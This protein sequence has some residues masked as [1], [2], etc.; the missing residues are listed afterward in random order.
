MSNASSAEQPMHAT[1]TSAAVAERNAR[2]PGTAV[3]RIALI[4]N[5][6][7]GKT[8]LFNRLCGMRARTANFPG[9]TVD[10]RRGTCARASKPTEIIDLPGVYALDLD[11]PESMLCRDC[12]DGR[13]AECRPD[14]V[15]VVLDATNLRRSLQLAAS[16]IA[17]QKPMVVA[18]NMVDL[19]AR[20][21]LTI[22]TE[23]L[24]E[25]LGCPVR[26][27]CAR[28]GEGVDELVATLESATP[29]RRDLPLPRRGDPP[30]IA[31]TAAWADEVVRQSVGGDHALG[32]AEDTFTDRLDQAFT[33]PVLGVLVFVLVMTALFATIFWLADL[34][35]SLIE[36]VFAWM[37]S[38]VEASLPAGP[39]AELLANGVVAGVGA[40]VVFLPQ[41]CLLFFLLTLLED[42]GYLARAAFVM[43]R[44]LCRF[45]LP[46][47][48]FVPLLSSHACAIPG[49]MST[50]LIPDRHERLATILVAPFMSCSARIP[51]YVLMLGLLFAD[52]P[53]L[54]GVAFVGCYALG[55][56]AAMFTALLFRRTLLKGR[57][58]PMVLELPSY[59]LP[60]LRTAVL[61]TIDRARLFLR[62]AGSVILAIA[63]IMWWLSAYPKS[64]PPPEAQAMIVQAESSSD[65]EHAD[66]LLA[67]ADTV[68][69]RN[70]QLNSFAGRLG[71]LFQP[72]FA[73]LGAD[74]QIT[75]AILT[76]FL[77]RE[78][79]QGTM[80]ILVGMDEDADSDRLLGAVRSAKRDDGSPLFN[81]PTTAAVLIFYVL[82]MQ[83]L[84][85]LAL[86]RRETGS[87]KWAAL[88]LGWMSGLAWIAGAITFALISA[89]S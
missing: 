11:L 22:S 7:T 66:A 71:E 21:G 9:S 70:Q 89:L 15:L 62:N 4:G 83:C 1:G 29:G 6:N 56:A 37:A 65:P 18:L 38:A 77:A 53:I 20:R 78:V 79:F 30:S 69:H 23:R 57:A 55:A 60:S 10:A 67:E 61:T 85:T 13:L 82:A 3:R 48:A 31:T 5:P 59:K 12:L 51:V 28:T 68:I 44:L 88:Q 73:P 86:T 43:D 36:G 24:A 32:T 52:R 45:G 41:I 72:V 74:R 14:A 47:Q 2:S 64:E 27:V 81:A 75:V 33:H 34:P 8:S 80:I 58:R 87:W 26:S 54:A 35:M 46:G 16:V 40:V 63:V 50:R 39:V 19:A 84:P 42:T 49:I 17:R 76:S 25:A